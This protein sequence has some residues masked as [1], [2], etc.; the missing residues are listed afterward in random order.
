[1]ATPTLKIHS[2]ESLKCPPCC[3]DKRWETSVRIFVYHKQQHHKSKCPICGRNLHTD[4]KANLADGN[5][6]ITLSHSRIKS[7]VS[8]YASGWK[9]Y[10][11]YYTQCPWS[12][13][14]VCFSDIITVNHIMQP[15]LFYSMYSRLFSAF[16][17]STYSSSNMYWDMDMKVHTGGRWWRKKGELLSTRGSRFKWWQA[18]IPLKCPWPKLWIYTSLRS[19]L[20]KLTQWSHLHAHKGKQKENLHNGI[21]RLPHNYYTHRPLPCFLLP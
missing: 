16:C 21:D 18:F 5:R 15:I 1:M 17:S 11:F 4:T 2:S 9:Q 7:V 13:S 12:A 19:A 14:L 3:W 20:L 6:I 10:I 8:A